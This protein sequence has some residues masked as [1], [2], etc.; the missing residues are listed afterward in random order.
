MAGSHPVQI[1][2]GL[3]PAH[4]ALTILHEPAHIL[5]HSGT[6][7]YHQHRGIY[8]T[9]AE[10]IAYIVAGVLGLDTSAWLTSAAPSPPRRPTASDL[11]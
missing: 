1:H 8:E 7:D 2:H 4:E 11:G 6:S 5:L 10:S 9:E 3:E